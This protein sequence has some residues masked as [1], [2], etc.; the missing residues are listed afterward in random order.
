MKVFLAV[1]YHLDASGDG[2][3][4]HVSNLCNHLAAGLWLPWL[5]YG[6]AQG[7]SAVW[8]GTAPHSGCL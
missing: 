4:V 3:A 2:M 7:Y 5:R 1:S 8:W 6:C